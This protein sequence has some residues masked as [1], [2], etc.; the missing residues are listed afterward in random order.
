[1]ETAER[2]RGNPRVRSGGK[3]QIRNVSQKNRGPQSGKLICGGRHARGPIAVERR[4]VRERGGDVDMQRV[5]H[6]HPEVERLGN[7][8]EGHP[9]HLAELRL[10]NR[11]ADGELQPRHPMRDGLDHGGRHGQMPETMGGDVDDEM[12][13]HGGESVG[14][15]HA[16]ETG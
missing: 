2:D 1:M 13:R 3:R 6:R 8:F 12:G 5:A 9:D 15:G 16:P 10:G 14:G 7:V 4:V 11:T